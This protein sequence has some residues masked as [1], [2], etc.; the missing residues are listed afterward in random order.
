MA[1]VSLSDQRALCLHVLTHRTSED[2]K[3][4]FV[5]VDGLRIIRQWMLAAV[6]DDCVGELRAM[7]ELLG[8]FSLDAKSLRRYELGKLLRRLTRL[9]STKNGIEE[10]NAEAKRFIGTSRNPTLTVRHNSPT[11]CRRLLD[12]LGPSDECHHWRDNCR[13]HLRSPGDFP[14]LERFRDPDKARLIHE[15]ATRGLQG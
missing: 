14:P 6:R 9:R 10:L 3:A 2:C 7:V 4:E 8:S 1:R 13:K 15:F 12:E 11:E 5:A